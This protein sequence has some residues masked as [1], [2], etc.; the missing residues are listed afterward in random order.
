MATPTVPLSGD[1]LYLEAG[2]VSRFSAPRTV[3]YGF[4]SSV[5]CVEALSSSEME[6]VFVLSD[7]NLVAAGVGAGLISALEDRAGTV[8]VHE[9]EPG[10]PKVSEIDSIGEAAREFG[11]K[12]IVA[13]GGGATMDSAK[14]V[15]ILARHDRSVRDYAGLEAEVPG[16]DITL[17]AVATTA[18]TGSESG[19]AAIV[20]DD[21][22]G[23]KLP[24]AAQHMMPD[25][26]VVDPELTLSV[27][28]RATAATG[29]DALCQAVGSYLSPFRH[30]ITDVMA[31]E[32]IALI[33]SNLIRAIQ[34]GGDLDARAAMAHGS[35]LS[36]L[37]MNNSEAI[38]DQFFD[39]VIGPRYRVPHG[40]TAGL[41]LPYV[42]Q[43]NRKVVGDRLATL[44]DILSESPA[45]TAE[46]RADQVVERFA[47]LAEEAGAPSLAEVG[48][49][50]DDLPGLAEKV[51][52]HFGVELGINPRSI[53]VDDA[54]SMLRAAYQREDPLRMSS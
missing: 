38:A 49:E 43:F 29:L 36:G 32:A 10:E 42:V 2:R 46:A 7:R 3:L 15:R 51:A 8:M 39:E 17:V 53:T 14:C 44:A 19:V 35:L 28:P 26:A 9:R 40:L 52:G 13:L 18:G 16:S 20:T 37:A 12:T 34:D 30:P 25:M 27:P 45:Y 54:L 5:E 47:R 41:L 1:R 11:P 22:T 4:G 48:V 23:E 50:E 6:R 24:V 31:H 21:E 33:S